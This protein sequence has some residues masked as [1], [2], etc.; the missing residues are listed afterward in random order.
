MSMY[1]INLLL[2]HDIY[3]SLFGIEKE[4][5]P[6]AKLHHS[7]KIFYM[8]QNPFIFMQLKDLGE[9]KIIE[10]L[11]KH[12]EIEAL[13][14]CATIPFHD[15][16]FLITTD[17]VN[18]KTHFPEGTTPYHIGWFSVAVNLSDVAA[19]GGKP[20]GM[21]LS[22]GMPKDKDI[23]FIKEFARGA[24]E[25]AQRFDM[26]ILGGDTKEMDSITICGTAFGIVKQKE[27]MSRYGMKVG[28]IVCVTGELGRAGYALSSTKKRKSMFDELLLITP[29]VNEG[30]SMA[31]LKVVT[32]SMDI[33]DGL[34]ASLY[35]LSELNDKGFIIYMKKIPIAKESDKEHAL[36]SGGDY[37]LLFTIPRKK[38]MVAKQKLKSMGC[39][40]TE[41]GEVIEEKKVLLIENEKEMIME[42]KGYEHFMEK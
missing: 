28:D 15:S 39:N 23:D 25:C 24:M 6:D 20:L 30:R 10:I 4:H 26:P 34:A 1:V 2:L 11:A 38:I 8:Q 16:F 7:F 42:N 35:Q 9:R 13:D 22:I 12:F 27:F 19:K 36:Y 40:L 21:V 14:D 17:M 3:K 32:S 18:E 31:S 29:R 41:I 33:S 37:E 5:N